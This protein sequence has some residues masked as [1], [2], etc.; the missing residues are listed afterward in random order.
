MR[1]RIT[2]AAFA[3]VIA[4]G[5]VVEHDDRVAIAHDRY[6]EAIYQATLPWEREAFHAQLAAMM[7]D[8]PARASW[9]LDRTGDRRAAQLARER[10]AESARRLDPGETT[11]AHLT[12]ALE[13]ATDGTGRPMTRADGADPGSL[14]LAAARAATATGAFRRGAAYLGT[15]IDLLGREGRG[16]TREERRMASATLRE[17]LGRTLRASGDLVGGIEATERALELIPEGPN[18]VRVRALCSLAQYLML[19]G[20]FAESARLAEEAVDL[21]DGAR[22]QRWPELAHAMC[23]LGVDVAYLGQLDRGLALLEASSIAARKARRL[24]DLMRTAL[25]RTTL[26]DLDARRTEAL[27][28]VTVSVRDARSGGLERTYG[29]FL[30]GNAADILFQLGRWA[31][32]ERECRAAMEWP[33]AGVAWF[34]PTL[35]L[36][37]VLVE[38]RADD[39]AATLMGQTLLQLDTMAAGQWSALV[40]RAAVSHALWR[41]DHRAALEVAAREWPR[42]LETDETAQVALAA[43][44][45]LEAAAEAAETARGARDLPLLAEATRVAS[46]VLREA[47]HRVAASAMSSAL[48]ARQEADLQLATARA[49]DRRVQGRGSARAWARLAEAWE[50]RGIPYQA[51]K[52][53]WWRALAELRGRGGREAARDALH[54]AWRLASPLPAAPLC[55]ALMDLAARSRHDLPI[56]DDHPVPVAPVPARRPETRRVA[57]P[58]S[59]VTGIPASGPI[60]QLIRPAAPVGQPFGLSPRELEVLLILSEGRTDREIAER[61]FISQRTVHIHVRRVLAKLGATSRTQAASIAWHAGVGPGA[62]STPG[63]R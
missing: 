42:V 45:C 4:S 51:A 55:S 62:P 61:L 19:D 26:L 57:L 35:Y 37:L 47:T 44:T 24:D 39:E 59:D 13:L 33:P 14:L 16:D 53:H 23:T 15:A 36:G 18:Q 49:H 50:E 30:R 5:L 6:A 22:D 38:S 27:D 40:Q 12:R 41:G 58:I 20:R 10:A 46:M 31:E 28:V 48:G 17:E 60:A 54:A 11:L 52:C 21:A 34:S 25:N 2:A 9:H 63:V 3:E 56:D 1:S 8:R 29:A 32:C 43:A 7:T